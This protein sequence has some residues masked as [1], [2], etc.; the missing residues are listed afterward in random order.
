M[1]RISD[2]GRPA[3]GCGR[4][5]ALSRIDEDCGEERNEDADGCRVQLLCEFDLHEGSD[6]RH[7][8]G[9]RL[10]MAEVR[11]DVLLPAV[12]IA[13]GRAM[14]ELPAVDT[15]GSLSHATRTHERGGDGAEAARPS[16]RRP[17][18]RKTANAKDPRTRLPALQRPPAGRHSGA[19]PALPRLPQQTQPGIEASASTAAR[20]LLFRALEP[21]EQEMGVRAGPTRT[22]VENSGA[23][24]RGHRARSTETAPG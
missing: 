9:A 14:R 3:P 22:P 1:S 23:R 5:P 16:G 21:V 13:V 11:L 17:N 20:M 12:A 19:D 2:L 24:N 15:G 6:A 18:E 4:E 8:D 7:V 10:E